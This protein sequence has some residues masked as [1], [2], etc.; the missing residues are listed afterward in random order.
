MICASFLFGP[1]TYFAQHKVSTVSCEMI[2][3][4]NSSYNPA[5]FLHPGGAHLLPDVS[6]ESQWIP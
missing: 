3:A 2:H 4:M 5:H 1:V 6:S